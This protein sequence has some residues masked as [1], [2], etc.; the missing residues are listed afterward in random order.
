MK[1]VGIKPASSHLSRYDNVVVMMYFGRLRYGFGILRYT[2]HTAHIHRYT[3][4]LVVRD[5]RVVLKLQRSTNGVGLSV[6]GWLR[7]RVSPST[8]SCCLLLK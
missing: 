2:H 7:E 3:E 1:T 4:W 8:G 6:S 5:V